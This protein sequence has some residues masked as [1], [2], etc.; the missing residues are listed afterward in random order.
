MCKHIIL[1]QECLKVNDINGF[2]LQKKMKSPKL[3]IRLDYFHVYFHKTR[4][5]AICIEAF[6]LIR[7]ILLG[8]S[9]VSQFL[10]L[11]LEFCIN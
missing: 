7:A 4:S 3:D 5:V 9:F 6:Y 11:L 2:S 10:V 1:F 8:L